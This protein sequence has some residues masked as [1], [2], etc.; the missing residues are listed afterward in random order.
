MTKCDIFGQPPTILSCH[1]VFDL[2]PP[3]APVPRAHSISFSAS[4]CAIVAPG[5]FDFRSFFA[6][7]GLTGSS[8]ADG[9][10][11]FAVLDQDNSGYIEEEE[12]K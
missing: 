4:L 8:E 3:H 1:S 9:E 6:R 2:S 12:L 5:T 10:K 7:V 11:V